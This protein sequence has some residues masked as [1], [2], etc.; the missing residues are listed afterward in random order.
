[1]V[2]RETD[3][4][5]NSTKEVLGFS[6]ILDP[7]LLEEMI[8]YNDE[9]NYDRIVSAELAIAQA[10]KMDPIYGKVGGSSDD[11]RIK[12]LYSRKNKNKLF[13]TSSGNTLTNNVRRNKLFR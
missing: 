10:M 4:N 8:Q 12:S 5:G 7:M 1:M 6:R 2:Y 11:D 13:P 3:E 9:G